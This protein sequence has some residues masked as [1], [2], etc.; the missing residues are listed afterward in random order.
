MTAARKTRQA[1][2]HQRESKK[3]IRHDDFSSAC[4]WLE[5]YAMV[6]EKAR[7]SFGTSTAAIPGRS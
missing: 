2:Q 1:A 4:L 5:I 7:S 6:G 3:L